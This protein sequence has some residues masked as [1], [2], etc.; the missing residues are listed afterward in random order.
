MS[1]CKQ[2]TVPSNGHAD[3][4]SL[5]LYFISNSSKGEAILNNSAIDLTS[6]NFTEN[7]CFTGKT[8]EC[9]GNISI[10]MIQKGYNSGSINYGR[11]YTI[12]SL[13]SDCDMRPVPGDTHYIVQWGMGT[14]CNPEYQSSF[15]GDINVTITYFT[16]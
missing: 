8:T 2:C 5:A 12:A 13:F 10:P 15:K 9:Y 3:N 4:A 7:G 14:I 16:Y 11:G 6:P 1:G